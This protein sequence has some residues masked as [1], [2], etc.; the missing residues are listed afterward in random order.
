MGETSRTLRSRFSE[1]ERYVRLNYDEPTGRHFRLPGHTEDDFLIQVIE[2]M[3]G[4]ANSP[5][6][7]KVRKDHEKGWIA[8]LK[9]TA[10]LGINVRTG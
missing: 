6:C 10:P 2:L 4:R 1:H 3:Q 5:A 7:K 9:T 8:N